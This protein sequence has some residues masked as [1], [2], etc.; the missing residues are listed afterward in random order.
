MSDSSTL[1]ADTET[2]KKYILSQSH[3]IIRVCAS[4]GCEMAGFGDKASHA[5]YILVKDGVCGAVVEIKSRE[6]TLDKLKAFDNPSGY[7]IS[8]HK[9]VYGEDIA[10]RLGA[11]FYVFA[12]LLHGD[13]IIVYFKVFDSHGKPMFDYPTDITETQETCEKKKKVSRVNAYLPLEHMRILKEEEGGIKSILK[14]GV[15]EKE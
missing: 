9:L 1:A 11:P 6:L 2:G 7:L 8:N 10:R 5:D 15:D 13:D 3:T 14:D 4:L 12:R